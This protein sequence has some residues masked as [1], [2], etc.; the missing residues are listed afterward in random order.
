MTELLGSPHTAIHMAVWHEFF[1][2]AGTGAA[3]LLG[4]LFVALSVNKDSIAARPLLRSLARQTFWSFGLVLIV[5]LLCLAPERALSLRGL[6]VSLTLGILAA[7]LFSATAHWRTLQ[8][9]RRSGRE[10]SDRSQENQREY[11][12][13][14]GIYNTGLGCIFLAGVGL[15][16]GSV[17]SVRWLLPAILLLGALALNN[18]W[19]LVLRVDE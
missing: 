18:A 6:G 17:D 13:R 15:W 19:G 5:S 3:T 16:R 4:L 9:S 1:V 14:V 11:L 7:S 10:A 8:E 2:L 12:L